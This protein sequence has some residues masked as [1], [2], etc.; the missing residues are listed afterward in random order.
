LLA[1]LAGP[2]ALAATPALADVL[3]RDTVSQSQVPPAAACATGSAASFRGE[4]SGSLPG[5]FTDTFCY[6]GPPPGPG[7]SEEVVG[8]PWQLAGSTTTL[9]GYFCSGGTIQW[10][11]AGTQASVNAPLRTAN[12][13][14]GGPIGTG[15]LV[16][17]WSRLVTPATFEGT[18]TI[19]L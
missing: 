9:S 10:N 15:S 5:T 18:F 4:A 2:L 11:S 7:V 12:A 8:G 16:G 6:L 13:T 3:Y 17:T 14:C 1:L 19:T